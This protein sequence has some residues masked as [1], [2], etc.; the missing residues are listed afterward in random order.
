MEAPV[1]VYPDIVSKKASVKEGMVPEIIK[2]SAPKREETTHVSATV[3]NPS[4]TESSAGFGHRRFKRR[5][6]PS[7]PTI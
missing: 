5:P 7:M 6:N 2:G 1:V 3:K 4:R